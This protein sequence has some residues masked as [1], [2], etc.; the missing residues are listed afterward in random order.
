MNLEELRAKHSNLTY[1]RFWHEITGNDLLVSFEFVLSGSEGANDQPSQ[2]SAQKAFFPT[3]RIE[4]CASNFA[5]IPIT[6]QN[7]L[8][9]HLGMAELLSYWKLACPATI[10]IEAASALAKPMTVD[11]LRWWHHLLVFGM[12]EFYFVNNITTF[13]KQ[14][15]V[16]W[17]VTDAAGKIVETYESEDLAALA[18]SQKN[19]RDNTD[20]KTSKPGENQQNNQKTLIPVGGGK[21]SV[22]TLEFFSAL[23][24]SQTT[25][26]ILLLNPIPAAQAI[27]HEYNKNHTMP[28]IQVIRTLDPQLIE[29]N[30]GGYL[31]GHT[32][33]SSYLAFLS[34]TIA[35]LTGH[36]SIALSNEQSANE[37]NAFFHGLD[38]NHQYSK[39]S[40]FEFDFQAYAREFLPGKTQYFSLMRPLHELSI[41][42]IFA[43]A[44]Y[45][46]P[47]L[48]QH[49]LSCNV[50]GRKNEWC[51]ECPKCLFSFSLLFPFFGNHILD[52]NDTRLVTKQESDRLPRL[53]ASN[54]FENEHLIPLM[55]DLLGK[56]T[57]KPLECVGLYEETLVSAW[58]SIQLYRKY[59]FS[60]LPP[61]L[62]W[63]QKHVFHSMD[64]TE[65]EKIWNH[66]STSWNE[67]HAIPENLL[68]D[69][70]NWVAYQRKTT[71]LL[72]G[73]GREAKS[74]VQ[75]LSK[76][77]S[78]EHKEIEIWLGD[79]KP[80]DQLDPFWSNLIESKQAASFIQLTQIKQADQ[81]PMVFDTIIR[82]PGFS[83][84]KI[85][86]LQTIKAIEI[87]SNTQLF[88]DWASHQ[89]ANIVVI[90]ITGTKGKSTTTALIHTVLVDALG[91]DRVFLAGNIGTPPL[92][93]IEQIELQNSELLIEHLNELP[94][95]DAQKKIFVVLELSC[96]Q[97]SD[98]HASPH[99]AVVQAITPEHFDYYANMEE[100]VAAKSAI[101][102][103][104]T[105][106]DLVF[107]VLG[108]EHAGI[109]AQAS[110]GQKI[111]FSLKDFPGNVSNEPFEM[112][113]VG[114]H[115]KINAVPAL[116]IAGELGL[117]RGRA[118]NA[119]RHFPGLPHRLEYVTTKNDVSFY[120]DSLATTPEA[121]VAAISSFPKN[122]VH[123]FAGG[124]E[125]HL[126]FTPLAQG[127]LD[128]QV[129][130]LILFPPTGTRIKE[131]LEKFIKSHPAYHENHLPQCF[132]VE[133]MEEAIEL[134]GK[135][136][137]PGDTV[138][139]SPA[140]PS[141]GTFKDYAD[142][143]EQFKK[144]AKNI[145]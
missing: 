101:T 103:Y 77:A 97:L 57:H 120:N 59:G 111:G 125:R 79:E 38:I 8:L 110:L 118:A 11:Q 137:K 113:L 55:Q 65:L 22:V 128:H 142:R 81:K 63:V 107:F 40:T 47:N 33:F 106:N 51:G 35:H 129:K 117:D 76:K 19:W 60:Q 18:A 91:N 135:N 131:T 95:V 78:L 141:F 61:V 37:G 82:T 143:G 49:F 75:F 5:A 4:N 30:A 43:K 28:I 130:S 31:N 48:G 73:L 115:N 138:L 58:K 42:Q 29:M 92:E 134:A 93:V 145:T 16:T 121:A 80:L 26:S 17:K 12:S 50:G 126:D 62:E 53:F 52:Q 21:D 87:T 85:E 100:Y 136:A 23:S 14:K 98:L 10:T 108:N 39:S 124:Y 64:S 99:I 102:R 7:T 9:F 127:I 96:H 94:N 109:I 105:E 70:K 83:R 68:T 3:L 114:E 90:G 34:Y 13:G 54:L 122:S 72:V 66:L 24:A 71:I 144:L 104:Q 132:F 44:V 41:A 32:P 112:K 2:I 123:L 25:S 56:G 46:K 84:K 45:K 67:P 15:F 86:S 89:K 139:L 74:S 6:E 20:Q 36:T 88:F 140:A 116:L 69:F 1:R 27:A 133:T 119:A